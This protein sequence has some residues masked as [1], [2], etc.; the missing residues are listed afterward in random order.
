FDAGY[1]ANAIPPTKV[2][3]FF[4]NDAL[5]PILK[6]LIAYSARP[7]RTVETSFAIDSSG[8]GSSKY[9]R[10]YDFKYGV[11]KQRAVWTKAH[12]ACGT[13]THIVTAIRILDKDSADC[14]QF[15]PLVRE[16]RQGF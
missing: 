16:T 7:L 12:I 4:D 8:F 6:S 9:E 5:T 13:K 3:H 10:W 1:F 14:P 2:C 11:T 15:I